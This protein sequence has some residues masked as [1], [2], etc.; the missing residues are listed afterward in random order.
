[1]PEANLVPA[2]EKQV[3][4]T[5]RDEEKRVQREEASAIKEKRQTEAAVEK[6]KART[7]RDEKR[8]SQ[9]KKPG[10]FSGV[11]G[12]SASTAA[13]GTLAAGGAGATAAPSTGDKV[14]PTTIDRDH[15]PQDTIEHRAASEQEVETLATP[16]A[17]QAESPRIAPQDEAD[18]ETVPAPASHVE[19]A[20]ASNVEPAAVQ[21]TAAMEEAP[22]SPSKRESRVKSFFGRFR[23]KSPSAEDEDHDPFQQKA[24]PVGTPEAKRSTEAGPVGSSE[25]PR[26]DSMRDVA[27][28]GRTTRDS[29]ETDDMYGDAAEQ[30]P[31]DSPVSPV[32][33]TYHDRATVPSA[34]NEPTP[35][36]RD[37]S[38]S[39]SS[40]SSSDGDRPAAATE[41]TSPTATTDDGRGRQGLRQRLLK[42]VKPSSS[43]V[44]AQGKSRLSKDKERDSQPST[45][46][47][48]TGKTAETEGDGPTS[49]IASQGATGA[50]KKSQDTEEREEARDAF[51]EEVSLA[52]PPKLA[53]AR[54]ESPR[55]S[56]EGSR[57]HEEL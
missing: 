10:F 54:G 50:S 37:R 5:R 11:L 31:P 35:A 25:I 27:L 38:L 19:P 46:S 14:A 48:S 22:V 47:S 26:S 42:K 12:R 51:K 30:Q 16:D 4:R 56:R 17:V 33:E 40:L 43:G 9:G 21:T 15:V 6:E 49:R 3:E 44:G 34:A 53:N 1:M 8:K 55:G 41:A 24:Q 20:A 13:P 2:R 52:P 45:F 39:I 7:E 32:K 23:A 29:D 28:A 18:R 57:F 36:A